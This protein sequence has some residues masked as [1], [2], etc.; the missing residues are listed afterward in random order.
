MGN[1]VP[2]DFLKRSAGDRRVYF[3]EAARKRGLSPVIIE[4][5][6]WVCW[7]L[8]ILFDSR[9]GDHL[10]F[11]GGTSL[12]KVFGA[13]ARFSEDI[14]LSISPEYLG[15]ADVTNPATLSGNQAEK[16]MKAA[17]SSI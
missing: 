2:L 9:F 15:L 17:L 5:D 12:S 6:F 8:T 10:V 7:M 3:E 14:D 13:I 11:K 4:K 16:W 1:R